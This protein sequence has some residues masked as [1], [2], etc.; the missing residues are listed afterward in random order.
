MQASL[1][2]AIPARASDPNTSQLAAAA[3]RAYT[4]EL[5]AAI[6]NACTNTSRPLTQTEIANLVDQTHPHRWKTS[7]IITAC[8][9]AGLNRVGTVTIDGRSFST[10]T[11]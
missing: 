2:D 11:T 6:R 1:F 9:R 5:V 4:G 8:A 10:W 3:T 7:T